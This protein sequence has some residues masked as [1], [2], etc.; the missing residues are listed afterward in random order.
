MTEAKSLK[1]KIASGAF[2]LGATK[3]VGQAISWVITI[4]V[5]RILAPE[6]YGLM[7]MA[8]LM[9]GLLLL[10]NELGLGVAIIQ[11]PDLAEEEISNLF[12]AILGLNIAIFLTAFFVA[13]L[14]SAFFREPRL[15]RIIQVLSVSFVM[16]GFGTVSQNLL[17]REMLFKNR[18]LS[19]FGGNLVGGVSVLLFALQGFG[20]WS[21]VYGYLIQAAISNVLYFL[22]R[23]LRIHWRFSL[24]KIIGMI[25]F[26]ARVAA[27]RVLWYISSNADYAVA[28][29]FL[30]KISLGYY[31]LAFQ[32]ASIP[33]DKIVSVIT[34]VALPSFSA[35]QKDAPKLQ[36]YYLRMVGMVAFITF[37]LFLGLFLVAD[38]AVH[39]FLTDKWSPMIIPL[40]ILCI[41][42]CLRAVETM[43]A[44]LILAKGKPNIIMYNNLLQAIVLPISFY[45]GAKYGLEGLSYAWLI[46]WP[47]L[48]AII[49]YQTLKLIGLSFTDYFSEMKQVIVGTVVMVILVM[50]V[51]RGF[52]EGVSH[53]FQF[54]ITSMTGAFLY[55]SYAVCFNRGLIDDAIGILRRKELA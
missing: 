53:L 10:F 19:E 41:V 32:F 49:T 18:S 44:P 5:V 45:I 23:P 29:R 16:S 43:N 40:K 35:V 55:L 30:G 33:L 4:Y 1:G 42:S 14:A 37:P 51:Q 25:Q 12:W 17:N 6:D 11:K 52:L 48:F 7:G 38:S 39:L 26:G 21:L 13:P 28:G 50:I 54:I 24:K 47:I 22:F 31:N 15:T 27:A 36:R 9:N 3:S 34:Q 46:I 20:V 8:V 2:W